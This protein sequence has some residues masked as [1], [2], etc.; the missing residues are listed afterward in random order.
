M[1]DLGKVVMNNETPEVFAEVM[2]KTYNENL[3]SITAEE[4]IYGYNHTEIGA[5][6]VEKW[7]LSKLLIKILEK[8]HL[9]NC[10]LEDIGEASVAKSI[11]CVNLAD[12]IC[13]F[14]GIGYR[15]PDDTILL[16]ELPSAVFLNM[17]KDRLDTLN[18]EINNT[19]NSEKSAFQ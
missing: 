7:G 18:E 1:H 3:D 10:K 11:A 4:E 15:D 17:T 13:K 14:L 2:M 19:Y 8:H 9:N 6:V 12:C 16:H 5:R